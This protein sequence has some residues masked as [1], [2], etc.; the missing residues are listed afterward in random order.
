VETT[1]PRAKVR[2]AKAVMAGELQASSGVRYQMERC[3]NC[4]AC[5]YECPSGVEPNMIALAMRAVYA[6][7]Y[8]IHPIKRLV[9]RVGL[10]R[11]RLMAWVLKGFGIVQQVSAIELQNN[12]L[13]HLLP[14]VGLRRDKDL[15]ILG[16]RTLMSRLRERILPL[17]ETK[18]KVLYFPG[19]A[20]N[21]LYPEMGLA[22][23]SILRKL[24]AEVL[25]P[26]NLVCCSTPV[27]NSGDL[28]MARVLASRNV[29]IMLEADVEAVVTSCGS[30]GLTIKHEWANTLGVE[31]A[32]KIASKVM[33]ITE[34]V[35]RYVNERMIVRLETPEAVTYHD[36]CHL[37]RGMSVYTEPRH[38]LAAALGDRFV[39][40]KQ[41][42][43]CCGGGGTFSLFHP[44]LSQ[45]VAAVK[46][47]CISESGAQIAAAGC[48]ACI[49]QLRDS[50]VHRGMS[51]KAVHTAEIIDQALQ[52]SV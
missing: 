15:P 39:E 11:P 6:R 24:G 52:P 17:G 19:C 37:R 49:M 3:L 14:L 5:A 28:E 22:V 41:A 8:G 9:F 10:S 31:D 18:I 30:C 4:R 50:F 51:Q 2:L 1:S 35:A 40:M 43:R 34:L 20:I 32:D 44:D 7:R 23:V 27:F 48:P 47:Q 25:I 45:E 29:R 13:R 46:L 36:S 12:P 38:L 33:D 21:F 42:D 16:R 26:H